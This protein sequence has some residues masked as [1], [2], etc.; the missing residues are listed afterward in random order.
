MRSIQIQRNPTGDKGIEW[1]AG[2]ERDM[3]AMEGAY[4]PPSV[5]KPKAPAASPK[6]SRG[7]GRELGG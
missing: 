3:E 1:P 2:W 4:N 5:V 6:V 7:R